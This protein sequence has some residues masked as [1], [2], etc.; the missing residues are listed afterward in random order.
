[1]IYI[2]FVALWWANDTAK[3]VLGDT[4]EDSLTA[5]NKNHG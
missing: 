5:K 1:M 4:S 2:I 3:Y